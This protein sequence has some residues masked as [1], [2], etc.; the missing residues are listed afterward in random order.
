MD[1]RYCSDPRMT[2]AVFE[3]EARVRRVLNAMLK[4]TLGE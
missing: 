4:A 2:H 3:I 1:S